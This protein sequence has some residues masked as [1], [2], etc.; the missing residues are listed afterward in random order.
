[1]NIFFHFTK[2]EKIFYKREYILVKFVN[3]GVSFTGGYQALNNVNIE[4]KSGEFVYIIGKSGAGKS[5]FL[6]LIYADLLPTRGVISVEGRDLNLMKR[7][8]VPFL[9]R[10][11]GVIFQDYKLLEN[12][13]VFDNVKLG[14]D[15]F[16]MKR[17]QAKERIWPLLKRV[18]MF[19]KRDDIVKNLSGGEK[20]RVAVA[21]AL[22][23]D[24]KIILADEPTGNL[25]MENAENIMTVLRECIAT[26]ATVIMATHDKLLRE[27]Y[28][29][30]EIE[31]EK[32]K[33]I[34]DGATYEL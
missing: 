3:V 34:K 24:P 7:I 18:G 8:E 33:V 12:L 14:L 30:R 29:S 13:S 23:N 10:Q 22:I 19:E 21:R 27:K 1:M 26:G 9:R 20:Q 31:L 4:I 17:T 5:T 16:Y 11:I 15:I 6:R 32:G 28:P 25:D 2:I